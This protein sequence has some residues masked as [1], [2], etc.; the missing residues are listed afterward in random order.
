MTANQ[1]WLAGSYKIR[2]SVRPPGFDPKALVQ[3]EAG[4]TLLTSEP[5][6]LKIEKPSLLK[7]MKWLGP[8]AP[9]VSGGSPVDEPYVIDVKLAPTLKDCA[10]SAP[11]TMLN[12]SRY[13]TS[14]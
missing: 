8:A 6:L 12:A 10:S 1:R 2:G 14:T 9:I 11:L 3:N 4:L 5:F 7:A 13:A